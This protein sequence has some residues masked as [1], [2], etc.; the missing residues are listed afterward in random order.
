MEVNPDVGD[1]KIKEQRQNVH[2][3]EGPS[4]NGS[5]DAGITL[6]DMRKG[7]RKGMQH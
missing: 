7:G 1:G 4:N 5:P 3:S 6:R 2:V